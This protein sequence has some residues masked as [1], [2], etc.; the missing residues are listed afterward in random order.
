[1]NIR[2]TVTADIEPALAC[3]VRA[4]ADDPITGFLL[5]TGPGY[6]D[7]LKR[8]FSLLMR[9]RIAL[10]IPVLVAH[11]DSGIVGATMGYSA[12]RPK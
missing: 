7:R 3:L 6:P 8:F 9:A 4:F 5:G 10:G 1:M 12:A 11:G 2:P